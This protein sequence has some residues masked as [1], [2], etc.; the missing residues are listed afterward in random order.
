MLGLFLAS[1]GL[2]TAVAGAAFLS[3]TGAADRRTPH[4]A[5]PLRFW[6]LYLAL[7]GVIGTGAIVATGIFLVVFK[8][9]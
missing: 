2:S 5:D 6:V 1:L 9:V 4:G 3:P 7:I 8:I